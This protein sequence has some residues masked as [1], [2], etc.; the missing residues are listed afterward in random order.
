MRPAD[1]DSPRRRPKAISPAGPAARGGQSPDTE[2]P[3]P[4]HGFRDAEIR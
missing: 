4:N 1:R 2:R 3:A